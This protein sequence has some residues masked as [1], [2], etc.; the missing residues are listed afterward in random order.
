MAAMAQGGIVGYFDGK[1]V[2]MEN[3]EEE[4][5]AEKAKKEIYHS[6]TWGHLQP[7]LKKLKEDAFTDIAERSGITPRESTITTDKSGF[8]KGTDNFNVPTTQ[9]GKYKPPVAKDRNQ[10]ITTMLPNMPD[11]NMI[12]PL[13]LR[14]KWIMCLKNQ[15]LEILRKI[16]KVKRMRI[17]SG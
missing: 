4:T 1:A 16:Y 2:D 14:K 6:W 12:P 15:S 11:Q 10:G 7:N 13:K 8:V 9:L 5:L 17:T 3:E